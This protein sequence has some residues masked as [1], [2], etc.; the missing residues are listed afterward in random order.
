MAADGETTELGR[1]GAHREQCTVQRTFERRARRLARRTRTRRRCRASSR[2]GRS[3]AACRVPSRRGWR[4]RAALVLVGAD[5]ARPIG[6]P[7]HAALID[8]GAW[9]DSA[10]DR[11][12]ERRQRVGEGEAAVVRER[13]EASV[14]RGTIAWA[15]E[16]AERAA[17]EVAA[18]RAEARHGSRVRRCCRRRSC[19]GT[20]SADATRPGKLSIASAVPTPLPYGAVLSVMVVLDNVQTGIGVEVQATAIQSGVVARD[21]RVLDLGGGVAARAGSRHRRRSP[22]CRRTSTARR[23]ACCRRGWRSRRRSSHGCD[24]TVVST[25]VNSPLPWLSM[26]PPCSPATLSVTTERAMSTTRPLARIPPPLASA[27]LPIT[28]RSASETGPSEWMA[29][30]PPSPAEVFESNVK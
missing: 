28:S 30:P 20:G 8:R 25:I 19:C 5:I 7:E 4:V 9:I 26:P 18:L 11:R 29:R 27:R 22:S 14:N 2:T 1:R 15:V 21:R 23:A 3:R 10:A 6:L 16:V 17:V 12:A 24:A 13:L